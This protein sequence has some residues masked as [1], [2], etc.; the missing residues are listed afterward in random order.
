MRTELSRHVPLAF[1]GRVVT[2]VSQ[3]AAQRAN[4]GIEILRPGEVQVVEELR[5]LD[6]LTRVDDRP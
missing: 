3:H 4:L 2:G 1:V 5:V 6:V